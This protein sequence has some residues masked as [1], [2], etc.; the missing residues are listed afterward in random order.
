MVPCRVLSLVRTRDYLFLRFLLH[1]VFCFLIQIISVVRSYRS[2]TKIII[3]RLRFTLHTGNI[4]LTFNGFDI[5]FIS[6]Y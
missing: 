4:L 1:K 6:T 5:T 2:Q 3:K